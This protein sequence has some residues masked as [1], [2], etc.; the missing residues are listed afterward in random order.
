MRWQQS[1]RPCVPVAVRR[2][3]ARKDTERMRHRG[4]E[5]QPAAI[6]GRK[7]ATTS[8]GVAWCAHLESFSN[9]ENRLSVAQRRRIWRFKTPDGEARE[10]LL[11]GSNKRRSYDCCFATARAFLTGPP[12]AGPLAI[13]FGQSGCGRYSDRERSSLSLWSLII[14]LSSCSIR[15]RKVFG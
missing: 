2:A 7:I 14:P 11:H 4:V 15:S 1:W 9:F 10:P 12:T 5:L 13:A 8:W 3:R 6:Q